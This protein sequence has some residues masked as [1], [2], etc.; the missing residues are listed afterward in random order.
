MHIQ[1]LHSTVAFVQFNT[2]KKHYHRAFSSRNHLAGTWKCSPSYKWIYNFYRYII[3]AYLYIYIIIYIYIPTDGVEKKMAKPICNLNCTLKKAPR[4]VEAKITRFTL[5]RSACERQRF[6]G[7]ST[8][9]ELVGSWVTNPNETSGIYSNPICWM[10]MKH[11][12]TATNQFLSVYCIHCIRN[13]FAILRN[14]KNQ[15]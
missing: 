6:D 12:C 10:K 11:M 13:I 4:F 7:H 5:A 14:K 15:P 9:K 8:G 1:V 3:M 2:V